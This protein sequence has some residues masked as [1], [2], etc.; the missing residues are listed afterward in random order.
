MDWVGILSMIKGNINHPI[1][2]LFS[3]QLGAFRY[4]KQGEY[5]Y[6]PVYFFVEDK[7]KFLTVNLRLHKNAVHA[8]RVRRIQ[9][10]SATS[11]S[12][13]NYKLIE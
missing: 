9:P 7:F 13:G 6:S 8:F 10:D 1:F 5:C 4:N 11:P 12:W 2:T 3:L